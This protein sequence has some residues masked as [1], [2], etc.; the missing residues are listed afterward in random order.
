MS[1]AVTIALDA[2]GD[3]RVLQS[4]R[5]DIRVRRGKDDWA[6]YFDPIPMGPGFDV[7]V[8]VGDDGSATVGPGY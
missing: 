7:M 1:R 8:L 6:I 3:H 5:C 4:K 2:L